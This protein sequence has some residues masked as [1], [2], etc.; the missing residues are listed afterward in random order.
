VRFARPLAEAPIPEGTIARAAVAAAVLSR[1]AAPLALMLAALVAAVVAQARFGAIADVS[2]M[3]TISEKWLDGAT[4]YVDFIETN[5]PAAILLYLL[6]VAL[7][8]A[9]GVHAEFSWSRP[10]ASPP[11]APRPPP[12]RQFSGAP[13]CSMSSAWGRWARRCSL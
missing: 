9:L 7:A 10:G 2:W 8:R 11:A 4:P 12:P 6:P 1:A 13:G 3:I 5:P